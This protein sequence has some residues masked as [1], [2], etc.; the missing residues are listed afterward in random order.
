[1]PHVHFILQRCWGYSLSDPLASFAIVLGAA[2]IIRAD[3]LF[4]KLNKNLER[5]IDGMKEKMLRE[6][7][8]ITESYA[9][10]TRAL[11][12]VEL[13]PME[14]PKDGAF[15]LLTAFHFQKLLNPKFTPEDL[16]A[17]R[18][19]TRGSVEKTARENVDLLIKSGIGKLKE[20]I[21]LS[22][23]PK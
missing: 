21:E 10:F 1:M 13:D 2:G 16:A 12:A 22:D 4:A 17:L 8:T 5:L 14:L 11:Q 9:A 19:L 3:C 6:M 23:P 18:K 20:G 7:L 15:A